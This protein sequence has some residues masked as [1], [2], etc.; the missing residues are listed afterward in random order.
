MNADLYKNS[1][2]YE[3]LTQSIYQAILSNEGFEQIKVEHNGKLVGR[4]G[5]EHQIDVYWKFKLANVEQSV[6]IE[7]KNYSSALT[8]EKV[9]NFHAVINDI[10]NCKGIM[11]T[12]VGY[13]DGAKKYAD[14]YGIDLKVLRKPT[15]EDWHG[16]IKDIHIN[17]ISKSPASDPEHPIEMSIILSPETE[18]QRKIIEQLQSEGKLNIPSGPDLFFVNKRKIPITEEMRWWIPQKLNVLHKEP[19]GP[20]EEVIKLEDSYVIINQDERAELLVRVEGVK[21]KY[22]V[23]EIENRE[24]ILH[25]EQIVQAI[26]KN[27]RTGE[28]E[29]VKRN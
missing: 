24:I 4:S 6:L 1:I 13:Q 23:E 21:V 18:E 19:G 22:W 14:F 20:Y 16:R 15:E 12:K 17:I 29:F 28:I 8:L 11:V 5:V 7:C 26:L 3:K 10:G 9:R 27:F 25:G 2:E